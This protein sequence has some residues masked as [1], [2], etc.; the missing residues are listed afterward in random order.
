MPTNLELKARITSLRTAERTA[1][2]LHARR[3]GILR[4]RDIYYRVTKG[5]VK[6]R[7]THGA[8]AELIVYSRSNARSARYSDYHILPISS[9]ETVHRL[10]KTFFGVLVEVRKNR[11]L[12]LYKN[13]RIHIDRVSRLGSFIEF[14]VIVGK[15]TKQARELMKQLKRAFE[16]RKH[17]IV[18][19]SYSDLLLSGKKS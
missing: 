15:S 11:I 10:N 7:I 19:G 5:R 17:N 16:I 14:E 2:N 4:Q 12:Y 13:A 8:G 6:L 3:I 18:G 9:P 1:C